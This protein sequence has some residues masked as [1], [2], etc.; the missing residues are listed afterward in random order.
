MADLSINLGSLKLKNPIVAGA[1]P[2]A[3]TVDHIK[4]CVDA[5]FGAVCTKT[6]AYLKYIQR[7]PRPRYT[8]VDYEIRPNDP[9]YVPDHYTWLHRE[10]NS[11][12]DPESFAK[13]IAA[14]APYAKEHDCKIIGSIN[15]RGLDEWRRMAK[16]YEEAGC[17]AL[18]LNFCCPFPPADM[19]EKP[20]D[21]FMGVAFTMHPEKGID[22]I[23]AVKETVKIPLFA[24]VGPDG[25][26]FERI[27]QMFK[28][29]GVD[30]ISMFAN[31]RLMRVD[32]ETGKAIN[33][34]PCAGTGPSFKA[35]SLGWIA[36]VAMAVPGLP[37]MGGRGAATWQDAVEFLMAG[38]SAV[39]FCSPIMLRGL[40]YVKEIL[41]GLEQFMERRHYDSPEEMVGKALKSI[42]PSTQDIIDKTKALYASADLK[43]CIGCG[44]CAQVCWYDAIKMYRKPKFV[45]ENCVGCTICSQVCPVRCIE[46]NERD[47]DE[48]HF[49]AFVAAHPEWAPADIKRER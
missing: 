48:D 32:I 49:K 20:E 39:Q 26:G 5:G 7:W 24:K 13:I 10:H 1:G 47:N 18:E 28:D 43:K 46:M 30:G 40:P 3:G 37:I 38:S 22:V 45:S 27:A 19:V 17:D 6:V 16:M 35:H 9:Y 4:A 33:Y 15:G 41:R 21:A 42:L 8:L 44:R 2:L 34:G 23:K 29:A 11:I 31:N 36:R 12:Y 14:A 25:Q